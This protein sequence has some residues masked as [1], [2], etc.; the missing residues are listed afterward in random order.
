MRKSSTDGVFNNFIITTPF[1]PFG[2]KTKKRLLSE[3]NASCRKGRSEGLFDDCL[4]VQGKS[5]LYSN[6][7]RRLA[8]W[9]SPDVTE[10][11]FFVDGLHRSHALTVVKSF[12]VREA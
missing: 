6:F 5:I 9:T 4:I 7:L 10:G 1:S 11:C 12:M 8:L 2:E 3:S